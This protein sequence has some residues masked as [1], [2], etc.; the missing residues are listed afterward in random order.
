MGIAMARGRSSEEGN[1]RSRGSKGGASNGGKKK[2]DALGLFDGLFLVVL[3]FRWI[4]SPEWKSKL[5]IIIK[6]CFFLD[7]KWRVLRCW[8]EFAR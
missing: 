4:P 6:K 1:S 7:R 3:T 5:P 8:N 2:L